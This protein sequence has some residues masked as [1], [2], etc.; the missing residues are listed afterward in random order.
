MNNLKPILKKVIPLTEKCKTWEGWRYHIDGSNQARQHP[1]TLVV[2]S[3]LNASGGILRYGKNLGHYCFS[4]SLWLTSLHLLAIYSTELVLNHSFTDTA[5]MLFASK[6]VLASVLAP[7]FC[8]NPG[9][10]R[11]KLFLVY[12]LSKLFLTRDVS[13]K[14]RFPRTRFPIV[15]WKYV[16]PLLQLEILLKG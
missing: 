10:N 12:K 9:C 16:L 7:L 13:H 4:L 11:K 14:I 2:K 5:V 3:F 8:C 6:L 15:M 1:L